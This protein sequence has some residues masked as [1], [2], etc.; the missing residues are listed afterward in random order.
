MDRIRRMARSARIDVRRHGLGKALYVAFL[1][2]LRY[3][4]W[5]KILRCHYVEEVNPRFFHL[6]REYAGSFF[7]PSALAEFTCDPESGLSEEFAE[8]AFGKGDKCYGF[9]HNGALRA[10]GWY[11]T[12]PTR[13]S[14]E[15][16]VHFSRDYI[17]MYK[18]FTH[19]S[20]RGKR[21]FAIGMTRALSLYRA[22]GYKG[23][24]LYIDARNLDSL[25]SCARM[26]FR[27]FGSIYVAKILGRSFVYTTPGCSRFRFRIECVPLGASAPS[28]PSPSSVSPASS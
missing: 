28:A 5:L 22:A 19:E 2:A 27:I 6:P 21:L 8:Y 12:T 7:A 20:H 23:M 9:T 4:R 18:G 26:G 10:Y 13:V 17:Y 15:L 25:K 16:R 24:L 3:H 1:K 11:A 14:P